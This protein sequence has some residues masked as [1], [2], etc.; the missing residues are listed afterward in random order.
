MD[1]ELKKTIDST[2][3]TSIEAYNEM[4]PSE[5]NLNKFTMQF[6]DI[7]NS[8]DFIHG[9]FMGELQGI[10]F[11]TARC[12]LGRDMIEEERTQLAIILKSKKS[13]VQSIIK[14]IMNSN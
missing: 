14:S 2:L 10:A 7:E 9:Y 5:K 11:A 13:R 4:K 6:G 3:D 8:F 1:I 12:T